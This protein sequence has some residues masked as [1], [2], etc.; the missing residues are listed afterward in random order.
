MVLSE[1]FKTNAIY[2]AG[3]TFF[4]SDEAMNIAKNLPAGSLASVS[5]EHQVSF[6]LLAALYAF[7]GPKLRQELIASCLKD[8]LL[9]AQSFW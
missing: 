8:L 9:K 4:A 1:K 7:A 5:A 3:D 6:R 2:F